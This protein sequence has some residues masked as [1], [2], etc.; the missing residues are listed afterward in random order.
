MNLI[1]IQ[2]R[3]ALKGFTLVE[4]LVVLGLFSSVM[5]I[6]VGALLSAQSINVK[7]QDSQSVLDNMNLSV[8]TMSREIRYGSEFHCD[9]TLEIA[10]QTASSS[11][12][13]DCQFVDATSG[14]GAVLIFKPNNFT[15]DDRVAYYVSEQG[16]LLKDE[17]IGGATTTYQ[18]TSDSVTIRSL[19]FYVTGAYT[20][21]GTTKNAVNA[22]DFDQPLITVTIDGETKPVKKYLQTIAG[23]G[24]AKRNIKAVRFTLQTSVSSRILDN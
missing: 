20:L 23:E 18:I 13:K 6:A 4:I 5:T 9:D 16:V 3:I 22:N 7:L 2:K 24:S 14:G 1:I 17:Y 19:V 10:L 8:E 12:R 15:S 11:L 21:S